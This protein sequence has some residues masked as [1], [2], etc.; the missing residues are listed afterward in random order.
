MDMLP[1]RPRST[2]IIIP[3]TELLC[4]LNKLRRVEDR[5]PLTV[6]PLAYLFI[7]P[8]QKQNLLQRI[9]SEYRIHVEGKQQ[10]EDYNYQ[11]ILNKTEHKL[12]VH[13][14]ALRERFEQQIHYLPF[15]NV[16]NQDQRYYFPRLFPSRD[17]KVFITDTDSKY[18]TSVVQ[19][20]A[21]NK[22][23]IRASHTF[24]LS[25]SFNALYDQTNPFVSS[26]P[27]FFTPITSPNESTRSFEPNLTRRSYSSRSNIYPD[28]SSIMSDSNDNFTQ[29]RG[30][31]ALRSPSVASSNS[32]PGLDRQNDGLF[33][34]PVADNPSSTV[35]RELRDFNRIQLSPANLHIE[36]AATVIQR[37]PARTNNNKGPPTENN[38]Q[39]LDLALDAPINGAASLAAQAAHSLPIQSLGARPKSS[40]SAFT[41]LK[42]R[43]QLNQSDEPENCRIEVARSAAA[44]VD[45]PT[46]QMAAILADQNNALQDEVLMLRAQIASLNDYQEKYGTTP[47]PH[48]HS[49]PLRSA[50]EQAQRNT[51]PPVRLVDS[52]PPLSAS[53]LA[54]NNALAERERVDELTRQQQQQ[55]QQR[56]VIQPS[57]SF[58]NSPFSPPMV[59]HGTLRSPSAVSPQ[60][61]P[62]VNVLQNQVLHLS[63]MI[64]SMQL[65]FEQ[66]KLT[67]VEKTAL[68]KLASQAAPEASTLIYA[69][70]KP[71]NIL[72][73]NEERDPKFLAILKGHAAVATIGTFDPDKNP[74]ADF[75]DTWDRILNYTKNY[76]IYAFEYVDLLM[77]VMKG[78]A[79]TLLNGMIREYKG[80]LDQIIEA[81]QDIFI[82][83][84]TIYDDVE[85][86]N[87]FQRLPNE[88]IK[89]TM[90]RAS[91]IME[92]LKPTCTAEA[93]PERKYHLLLALLKQLID[94]KTFRHLHSKELEHAQIGTKMDMKD[95]INLVA[96]Y[97][98]TH[99][100]IPKL[101]TKL[102]Y[103]INS[104]Q[105]TNHPDQQ[106]SELQELRLQINAL[107]PT[108]LKYDKTRSNVPP[109]RPKSY[110]SSSSMSSQPPLNSNP[111]FKSRMPEIRKILTAT[112]R[113]TAQ[114][115]QLKRAMSEPAGGNSFPPQSFYP[116][117][118]SSSG[119]LPSSQ[120]R[121]D[122][123]RDFKVNK[124]FN[125][126][127][128][129]QTSL[130]SNNSS[131]ASQRSW[132]SLSSY[133]Y[134]NRYSRDGRSR[135]RSYSRSFSRNRSFSRDR[136]SQSRNRDGSRGRYRTNSFSSSS[137][138]YYPNNRYN[139]NNRYNS[140][141][142]SY[143]NNYNRNP[144]FRKSFGKGNNSVT[145]TFYKCQICSKSHV[146]GQPCTSQTQRSR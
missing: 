134:P 7:T 74:K 106:L 13:N 142:K 75:R 33:S 126:N 71:D 107:A 129:R 59:T 118:F 34:P 2:P 104:L 141:N 66:T 26:S 102:H 88:N 10:F 5:R 81:I 121:P 68:T 38:Q 124:P 4:A 1:N 114:G 69:L 6:L 122:G 117:T 125:S 67:D 30:T 98:T 16:A 73:E 97:E 116:S 144:P 70:S 87:N 15:R 137:S 55:Q 83:Q 146:S 24:H 44:P 45:S 94:K 9:E 52:R 41:P 63:Q 72:P 133:Q 112:R 84:H 105:L 17:N 127:F 110:P 3:D 42:R 18:I 62:Q 27:E 46:N 54:L 91:M 140:N 19:V 99:D 37:G 120:R 60:V 51:P 131:N 39:A 132:Q 135:Q 25:S 136:R 109:N 14:K 65:Q 92:R 145:L 53:Y 64:Q 36:P 100:L 143:N 28:L 93:W 86:L 12:Y 8:E 23:L 95:V 21:G 78:S 85:E 138:S 57:T 90:R 77:T 49:P 108:R 43:L 111:A 20:T 103:N 11:I 101:A 96:L 48:L 35:N 61:N 32:T 76:K 29:H 40:S 139:G 50:Q 89:A 79:A 56:A 47:P 82:P 128:S 113:N 58:L 123:T 115:N 22:T 130:G 119:S 31:P 80:D